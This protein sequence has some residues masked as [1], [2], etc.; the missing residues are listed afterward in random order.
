MYPDTPTV[1]II[2]KAKM[3]PWT[4]RRATRGSYTVLSE[5][6]LLL[7][8]LRSPSAMMQDYRV[9]IRSANRYMKPRI[10][11]THGS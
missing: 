6:A 10:G 3:A 4:R 11:T 9:S 8:L 5:M 2:N 1:A 7:D